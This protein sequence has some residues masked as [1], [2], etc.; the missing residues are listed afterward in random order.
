[1]IPV[2]AKGWRPSNLVSAAGKTYLVLRT[3]PEESEQFKKAATNA[4]LVFSDFLRLAA[5]AALHAIEG[6]DHVRWPLSFSKESFEKAGKFE[7]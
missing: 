7:A 3:S 2:L 6:K 4:D 1:M 5:C